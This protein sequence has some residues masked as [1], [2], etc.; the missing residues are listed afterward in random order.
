MTDQWITESVVHRV[1]PDST[2]WEVGFHGPNL[3]PE[4]SLHISDAVQNVRI[5]LDYLAAG[6]VDSCGGDIAKAH[7]PYCWEEDGWPK[8][9]RTYL[10]GVAE[11]WLALVRACQPF[12]GSEHGVR[13]GRMADLSNVDKHRYLPPQ[14][15]FVTESEH[16]QPMAG[17][18]MSNVVA[19][20]P[21]PQPRVIP[22]G[23][24]NPIFRVRM[25]AAGDHP[26]PLRYPI[27]V[28]VGFGMYADGSPGP[29]Y[30]ELRMMIG[31]A[32]HVLGLAGEFDA[33][34]A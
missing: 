26:P 3:P 4:L 9:H 30:A 14:V 16:P 13:L 34:G 28:A 15:S 33:R 11:P 2:L 22:D 27:K 23:S 12:T 24:V 18:S 5:A 1:A 31:A 8:A 29:A 20:E 19:I 21:L 6:I 17:A 25:R 7:F 10:P 32:R